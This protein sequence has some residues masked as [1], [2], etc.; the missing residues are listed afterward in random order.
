MMMIGLEF[1][2]VLDD[3]DA[4]LAEHGVTDH[5]GEEL[6]GGDQW[7]R[8]FGHARRT[9]TEAGAQKSATPRDKALLVIS[10]VQNLFHISAWVWG[11]H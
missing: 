9:Y 5:D 2:N 6:I 8:V 7:N 3:A 4:V 1:A 11:M 10:D